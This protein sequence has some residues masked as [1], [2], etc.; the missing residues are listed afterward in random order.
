MLPNSLMVL[1]IPKSHGEISLECSTH[2]EGDKV[3]TSAVGVV[4][5]FRDRGVGGQGGHMP[6]NIFKIIKS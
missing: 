4:S 2:C 1:I 6:P 5:I 3:A